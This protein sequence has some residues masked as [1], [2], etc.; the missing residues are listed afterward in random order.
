MNLAE[1]RAGQTAE[2]LAL[3][4]GMGMRRKLEAMGVRPGKTVRKLSSQFMAGPVTILVDGRQVAMG[5]GIA[6]R[7]EVREVGP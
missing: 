2:V 5:R 3:S 1:L 7:V 4:G 6:R